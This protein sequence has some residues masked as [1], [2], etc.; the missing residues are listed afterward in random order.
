LKGR[1]KDRPGPKT[2]PD[3][4]PRI[5]NENHKETGLDIGINF[6]KGREEN[7]DSAAKAKKK[8]ERMKPLQDIRAIWRSIAG[9]GQPGSSEAML[10]LEAGYWV[11]RPDPVP[12]SDAVLGVASEAD[13]RDNGD[14]VQ[15]VPLRSCIQIIFLLCSQRVPQRSCPV[16]EALRPEVSHFVEPVFSN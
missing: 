5:K 4:R 9:S 14:R 13:R 3:S 7:F 2:G 10:C 6:Q 15:R 8:V 12:V 16:W 1:W 11:S